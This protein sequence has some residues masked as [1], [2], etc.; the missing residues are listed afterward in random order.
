MMADKPQSYEESYSVPET[1]GPL[2]EF[3]PKGIVPMETGQEVAKEVPGPF[4]EEALRSG[5]Y[6]AEDAVT[7]V[8]HEEEVPETIFGGWRGYQSAT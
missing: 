6:E 2:G 8:E 3:E 4:L 5:D 1:E 7:G